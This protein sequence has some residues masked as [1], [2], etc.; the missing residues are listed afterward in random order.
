VEYY[1]GQPRSRCSDCRVKHVPKKKGVKFTQTT[2][3]DPTTNEIQEIQQVVKVLNPQQPVD[4]SAT[5]KQDWLNYFR[6]SKAYMEDVKQKAIRLATQKSIE[7]KDNVER[8]RKEQRKI[9]SNIESKLKEKERIRRRKKY[10]RRASMELDDWDSDIEDSEIEDDFDREIRDL[11]NEEYDLREEIY[12]A[13]VLED[14]TKKI[15]DAAKH[16]TLPRRMSPKGNE[17]YEEIIAKVKDIIMARKPPAIPKSVCT[18]EWTEEKLNLVACCAFLRSDPCHMYIRRNPIIKSCLAMKLLYVTLEKQVL[19]PDVCTNI[20]EC[21][22]MPLP[23]CGLY[24]HF[25]ILSKDDILKKKPDCAHGWVP[26]TELPNPSKQEMQ[27]AKSLEFQARPSLS[28]ATSSE[29]ATYQPE[30]MA[31]WENT[32]HSY[33]PYVKKT[34]ELANSS[35]SQKDDSPEWK[36]MSADEVGA[37]LGPED[38]VHKCKLVNPNQ[39]SMTHWTANIL[40]LWMNVRVPSDKADDIPL[41]DEV[42]F[43]QPIVVPLMRDYGIG[44]PVRFEFFFFTVVFQHP[45]QGR[46]QFKLSERVLRMYNN[47]EL[48]NALDA[49]L[50][51]LNNTTK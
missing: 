35:T 21:S 16:M 3:R 15:L 18:L 33:E 36:R 47:Q 45:T 13:S 27:T 24:P 32:Y 12:T 17:I 29:L 34:Q 31:L 38:R 51:E 43:N 6:K 10:S 50:R 46:F 48:N 49:C 20:S 42:L 25:M 44:P 2:R 30:T 1:N 41:P 37:F 28:F 5:S 7:Q 4:E 9:K 39:I 23:G 19:G 40:S 26:L 8:L 11:E 14:D 22:D